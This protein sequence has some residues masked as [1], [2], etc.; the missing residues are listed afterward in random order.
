MTVLKD[1]QFEILPSAEASDGFVFGLGA[2]VSVNDGGFDPGDVEW[3]T[4]DTQNSRRGTTSFGRDVVA[5]KTWVWESHVNRTDTEE[6]VETLEDFAGYWQPETL[7][8]TAGALTA[9]RYRVAGR[10]RRIFGRPR[11]FAAPPTN[12]ILGGYVPVTHDF[13]LVDP[14]TY[15]DIESMATIGYSSSQPGGGFTLPAVAPIATLPSDNGVGGGQITVGGNARAYPVIRFTGPWTNPSLTTDDW[16]LK[17]TGSI[18]PTGWIEIDSRPWALTVLDQSGASRVSGL[19][20][21]VWLE[22][23]W[24][25]PKS[26]PQ[27]SLGG[28]ATGGSATAQIRWRNT[29]KSI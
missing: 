3:I 2:A 14:Y 4:Q 10:D 18:G 28:T 12:Q 25:A 13:Q 1:H 29:W 15:D 22:D 5:A 6:A 27:I 16:T 26:Q 24:F 8:R 23:L 7:S 19:D 9:L 21:R 11:R 20:R 17:W